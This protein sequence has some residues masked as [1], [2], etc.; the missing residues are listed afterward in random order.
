MK[1]FRPVTLR[2]VFAAWIAGL[3]TTAGQTAELG[4]NLSSAKS[5]DNVSLGSTLVPIRSVDGDVGQYGERDYS[6]RGSIAIDREVSQSGRARDAYKATPGPVMNVP[7]Q[8]TSFTAFTVQPQVERRDLLG[9]DLSIATR[10]FIPRECRSGL[11]MVLLE[12]SCISR[13]LG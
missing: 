4:F 8:G 11:F 7:D 2:C 1:S 13:G 3:F 5:L 10:R 6:L 12:R 9:L